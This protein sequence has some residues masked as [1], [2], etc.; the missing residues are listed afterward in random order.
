MN[1][2]HSR[3]AGR[4]L[5]VPALLL[6]PLSS[7]AAGIVVSADTYI[8]A[9]ANTNLNSGT[10]TSISVGNGNA[11]LIMM[12]QSSLPGSLNSANITKATL[13][14]Y[15]NKVLVAGGL[16]F[17]QVTSSWTETGVTYTTRPSTASAFGINV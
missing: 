3:R 1:S 12:D 7:W 13:T 16:D 11:A 8:S 4:L 14:V 9:G 5:M 10:L 2:K 15:L 17:S 6:A